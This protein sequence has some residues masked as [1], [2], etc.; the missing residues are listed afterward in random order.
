MSLGFRVLPGG[1]AG[2]IV[3]EPG[4]ASFA[5]WS[6]RAWRSGRSPARLDGGACP[7]AL[8]ADASVPPAYWGAPSGLACLDTVTSEVWETGYGHHITRLMVLSNLATLLGVSPREVTDWFWAAYTDAYDWVVEP[9][10]LGMGTFA[11]GDLF[12]TKPYVS[13]AAYIAKMSDY[14]GD[15]A[16]SPKRDCPITAL[17]WDFLDRNEPRLRD[18]PRVAMP[19]RSLERRSNKRRDEDR[20]V[21]SWVMETLGAGEVLHPRDR[22]SEV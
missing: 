20:R 17:Y 9:N 22:P 5:G 3:K 18:N 15:C 6:G 12:T 4:D 8:D 13:G 10:V 19:L 21:R 11:L 7:S 2:P 16:F 14:C 1:A